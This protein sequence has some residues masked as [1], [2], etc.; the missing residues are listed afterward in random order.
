MTILGPL[1]HYLVIALLLLGLPLPVMAAR[2]N[3]ICRNA[4]TC[5]TIVTDTF[6]W[7]P[8]PA[9]SRFLTAPSI[10]GL[11]NRT[12]VASDPRRRIELTG[13]GIAHE[14]F[15]GS[16][17]SS[18]TF[19]G[20]SGK[21]TYVIGGG[22]ASGLIALQGDKR[23]KV[24]STT[25]EGDSV[26]ASSDDVDYVHIDSPLQRGTG[27]IKMAN[28]PNGPAKSFRGSGELGSPCEASWSVDSTRR[29]IPRL[30]F[31][32]SSWPSLSDTYINVQ[33]WIEDFWSLF[34]PNPFAKPTPFPGVASVSGL[35]VSSTSADRIFLPAEDFAFNG[36]PLNTLE[37]V[38]ILGIKNFRSEPSI[39]LKLEELDQLLSESKGLEGIPT[40][41]AP[42]IYF[43]DE[44][45]LVSSLNSEPLGTSANPGK[46]IVRL[47]D[48]R[49]RPQALTPD[50]RE[51]IDLAPNQTLYQSTFLVFEPSNLPTVKTT[52]D[53]PYSDFKAVSVPSTAWMITGWIR[54]ISSSKEWPISLSTIVI[55]LSICGLAM[56]RW[57]WITRFPKADDSLTELKV[58]ERDDNRTVKVSSTI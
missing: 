3:E 15:V 52:A 20:A 1:K 35:D 56:L 40:D 57:F 11:T 17:S 5:G 58:D 46:P 44:G 23:F 39:T 18:Q 54:Q 45:L 33:Q 43:E 2:C 7:T 8:S 29:S 32:T 25:E 38:P 26:I 21:N 24:A 6:F 37:N 4:S 27:L 51:G 49:G 50:R 9:D 42:L 19:N 47:L 41:I 36:K 14:L 34:K 30:A 55:L 16:I 22:S 28:D 13:L 31:L 12:Y 48:R 53:S 10:R